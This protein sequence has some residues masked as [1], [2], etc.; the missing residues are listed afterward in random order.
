MEEMLLESGLITIS[1]VVRKEESVE[2]KL[3]RTAKVIKNLLVEI[4]PEYLNPA[5]NELITINK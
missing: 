3:E 5:Y 4:Q 2:K 1:D